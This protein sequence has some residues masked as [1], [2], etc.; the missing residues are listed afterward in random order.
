M[1]CIGYFFKFLYSYILLLYLYSQNIP[2]NTA[3]KRSLSSSEL[4]RM[5]KCIVYLYLLTIG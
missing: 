1:L 2:A 5:E 4:L 3:P